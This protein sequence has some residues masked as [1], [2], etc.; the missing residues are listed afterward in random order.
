[1]GRK[2]AIVALLL[3]P[4]ALIAQS[5]ES[6]TGGEAT[7]AAGVEFSTFN[8]DW[9]CPTSAPFG[10]QTQLYGP[11]AVFN[12]DLHQKYGIEG[13]A[14]WLHWHGNGGFVESNY[15]VG[16]R[17]RLYR[18]SRMTL[19]GKL[20]MGGGWITTPNYPAAGSLKGSYF[21]Y[22]PGATV[23]YRLTRMIALRADYEFQLWPSFAGPPTYDP[24]TGK[25]I[26]HQSGLTPNG[27]SVGV[28]YRFLGP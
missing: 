25:V 9:G 22:A 20:L 15:L 16:P 13:E 3:L 2:I 5:S 1:M 11:T 7:V 6:A 4:T 24:S 19:W 27:V 10:C 26:Q 17:Y 21:A 28:V 12:F 23:N 18:F 14:R 8:P